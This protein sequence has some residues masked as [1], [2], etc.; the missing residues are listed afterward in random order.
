MNGGFDYG[1]AR[2]RAMRS[3]MISRD[4]YR[5]LVTATTIERIL[6]V[7]GDTDYAPDVETAI[8]RYRGP[9]RY[10]RAL[11]AHLAGTLRSVQ[12][13]YDGPPRRDVELLLLHHDLDNLVTI[14]RGQAALPGSA[15]TASLL[16]PA[17]SLDHAALEELA[18]QPGL[19]ETVE[20]MV[21]WGVPSRDTARNV[22]HVWPQ[23]D[24]TGNIA[25][26]ET[27]LAAAYAAHLAESIDPRGGHLSV[28]LA[29]W[30]DT[31]NI[32][33]SLRLR[34]SRLDG[35]PVPAVEPL[36]GGRIGAG[37]ISAAIT[38]TAADAAATLGALAPIPG[39]DAA[40]DAWAEHER[41]DVLS[42]DL[43]AARTRWAVSLFHRGDPLGIDVPL[44][45]IAAKENEVRNLRLVGQGCIHGVAPPDIEARL[46]VP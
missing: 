10:D 17:G 3:R 11:S 2:V 22:L 29:S 43:A 23:Y 1:N 39:W 5:E 20:L 41:I 16:V 31:I 35:E 15:E 6:G 24:R 13:F 33:T 42:D 38:A 34:A 7:L 18:R 4:V 28:M 46:V 26:L 9:E 36:P 27:A 14:V 32:L 30:I 19:R 40:L 44:A 25:V 21:A 8:T 12:G 37:A 45:F